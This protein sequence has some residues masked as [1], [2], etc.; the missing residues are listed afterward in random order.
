MK[1]SQILLTLIL[2]YI[3]N[4]TDPS[5]LLLLFLALKLNKVHNLNNEFGT[6]ASQHLVYR[7][8]P[9]ESQKSNT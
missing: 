1:Y 6:A 3:I 2:S 8:A 4:T 5:E 7:P 9:A